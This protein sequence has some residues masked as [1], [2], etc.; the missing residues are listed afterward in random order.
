MIAINGVII[1][2]ESQLTSI[3]QGLEANETK[4]G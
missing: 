1:S 4:N 2:K 3:Y